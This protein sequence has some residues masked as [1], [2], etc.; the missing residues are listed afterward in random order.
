MKDFKKYLKELGNNPNFRIEGS[1]RKNTI[2]VICIKTN[3]LYS[4][5]PGD[6]AV[7]PLKNWVN[8][9]EIK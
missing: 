6:K 4:V 9:K 5:H 3:Q 2:K 8:K 1:G 7:K